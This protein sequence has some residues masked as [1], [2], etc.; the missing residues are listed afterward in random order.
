MTTSVNSPADV[1]NLSLGRIG[2]KLRVGSLYDGSPASKAALDIYGQTRDEQ[3]RLADWGFAQ[4]E[5][6][7]TLQKVAPV[8]GY[9]PG[10]S[11]WNPA[12]NP[13]VPWIFQYQYP[14]DCIKVRSVR[15]A[16]QI[17]P[18]FLPTPNVFNIAND[19][20]FTPPQKVILTNLS[21][22]IAVYTRR[23]TNPATWEPS[24]VEGLAAALARR[25]APYLTDLNAEKIEEQDEVAETQIA[26]MTQG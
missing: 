14:A 11:T 16:P 22:A 3:L 18:N 7:L 20:A 23:V 2:Y 5:V 8:G 26:A 6:Q 13:Q 25:L 15:G 10:I 21:G 24:F 12:T 1:V 9:V 19:N 17:I 4:G